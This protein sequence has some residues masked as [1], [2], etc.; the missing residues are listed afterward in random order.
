M[1][2]ILIYIFI[3]VVGIFPVL[4]NAE[5]VN[6]LI[7]INTNATVK[8]E[9]FDYNNLMYDTSST[10]AIITF[11][12]I[13]NNTHSKTAVSINLLLFGNDKKNIGLVSY[14]SD[15]DLD[16]N[17][18]GFKLLGEEAK[19]FS[20]KVVSKYF[21]EGKSSNDVKYVAVMDDNKYCHVGG[22]TNYKD[23][24]ID[25]IANGVSNKDNVNGIQKVLLYIQENNLQKTI[26]IGA[27]GLILF[28]ILIM[29]IKTIIKKISRK[30]E[31]YEPKE[32]IKEETVDLSYDNMTLD[33]D[34]IVN[35]DVSIG[36]NT[37][38]DTSVEEEKK[39]EEE[40]DLTKFFN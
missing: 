31:L 9:K 25:E 5:E 4:V 17:Y 18:S 38:N 33:D 30:K 1:K 16:S 22:Y 34:T 29:I 23:K 7:P 8:T 24:T 11:E 3:L 28:I 36:A 27:V 26:I 10:T 37:S 15:K 21:V 19:P 40:S 14:C 6:T 20:I 12:S 35:N 39:D 32:E 2:K 13:K